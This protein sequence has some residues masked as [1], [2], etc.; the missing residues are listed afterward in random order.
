MVN[1]KSPAHLGVPMTGGPINIPIAE[2]V[3]IKC[4]VCGSI[5]FDQAFKMGIISKLHPSNPTKQDQLV[6]MEV[7]NTTRCRICKERFGVPKEEV[8]NDDD[9]I[10]KDSIPAEAT[11]P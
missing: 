7:L 11:D 2:L 4:P 1:N 10:P 8:K 3:Y 6:R 9:K 5:L